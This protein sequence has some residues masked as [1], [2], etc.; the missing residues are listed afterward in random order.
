MNMKLTHFIPLLTLMALTT[1]GCG[2]IRNFI[3]QKKPSK[4]VAPTE[5]VPVADANAVTTPAADKSAELAGEWSIIEVNGEEVVVNGEDHPKLTLTPSDS[6]ASVINIIAFNGCNYLNGVWNLTDNRLVKGG[7]FISTLKA[8]PDARYEYAVNNALNST[9]SFEITDPTNV[10]LNSAT[11]QTVM[12][13]RKRNLA[14]LNGAW[15]VTSIE[16][17][18]I[19]ARIMIVIDVDE[20]R[21]HGNAGCNMLNGEIVVNLDKGNGIEFKNL[22]TSRMM[23]PDIATEQAFLLALENVDTADKGANDNEAVL[24]NTAGQVIITLTRLTPEELAEM[25]E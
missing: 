19:S 9:A 13:L 25:D 5:V 2:T 14:F 23:C 15:R 12:K 24:K 1:T 16:G 8:C 6:D 4:T 22:A 3:D 21:V 7:E 20:N 18:E 10:S 11:G 17:Q